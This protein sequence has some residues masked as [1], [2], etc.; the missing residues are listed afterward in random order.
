M[1]WLSGVVSLSDRCLAVTTPPITLLIFVSRGKT[2]YPWE[3]MMLKGLGIR[4]Y[5][6]R[7]RGLNH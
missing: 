7:N 4:A 3:V 5:G 1:A 6:S 2:I